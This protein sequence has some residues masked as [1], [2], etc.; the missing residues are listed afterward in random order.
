[1]CAISKKDSKSKT[2]SSTSLETWCGS[3]VISTPEFK[4]GESYTLYSGFEKIETFTVTTSTTTIGTLSGQ[5]NGRAPMMNGKILP[6]DRRVLPKQVA[7]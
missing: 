1:M 2:V 6:N 7:P 4:I 3:L 5:G